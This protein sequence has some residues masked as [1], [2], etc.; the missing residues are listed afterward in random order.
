MIS[1]LHFFFC[2]YVAPLITTVY[3]CGVM[4]GGIIFG[5]LSDRYG[6]KY[7][8]L[9]CLYTQCLI[10][11]GLHF[12]RRLVVFIGLRFIQ[13]I[14]IQVIWK[15]DDR[16]KLFWVIQMLEWLLSSKVYFIFL[17]T[18]MCY[19]CNGHG[20]L[21]PTISSPCWLRYR[22]LLGN[23][24]DNLGIDCKIRSALEVHSTR[25]QH[26]HN[27]YIILYL[28]HTRICEVASF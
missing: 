15:D 14:F 8:M 2:R 21:C 17:G 28:D 26:T 27:C 20:T 1:K 11:V 13:G 9:V 18:A 7:M 5:S 23:R 24:G 16:W 25:Y 3:F 19:L 10:G 12:V 22:G 6:R 4:L